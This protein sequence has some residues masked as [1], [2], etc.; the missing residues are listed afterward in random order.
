MAWRDTQTALGHFGRARVR[1]DAHPEATAFMLALVALIVVVLKSGIGVFPSWPFL[2]NLAE[3]WSDPS[4]APLLVPPADYL[5]GNFV[6]AWLAGA[7]GFV[8]PHAYIAFNLALA[9]VAIVLPFL[10][11]V[12]RRRVRTAAL[13]FIAI[14]GGP[15]A[16]VLVTW[17]GG[18]DAVSVIGI[19]IA[20]LARHSIVSGVGWLI[21][22]L[23]HPSLAL[24]GFA[25][26]IPIVALTSDRSA[27]VRR[28]VIGLVGVVL[29]AL[30]SMRVIDA[31]GG[32]TN[33]WEW[34]L[35]NE[36]MPTAT[37]ILALFLPALFGAVGVMWFVFLRPSFLH[38]WVV[39]TLVIQ[40]VVLTVLL[41]F[42]VLDVTRVIAL[43]MCAPLLTWIAVA[44]ST[45]GSR[46]VG[47]IDRQLLLPAVILPIPL[48][49]E[50]N[51]F[52][53]DPASTPS[54]FES[55]ELPEWY[56]R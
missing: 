25:A 14:V 56:P 28:V 24:L 50:G 44:E 51:V 32:A 15:I 5:K 7:L 54:V 13:L 40:I 42:F 9:A 37:E 23:N 31:W 52:F 45:H 4:L 46:S 22:G 35:T 2:L 12:V 1:V 26:W 48:V 43:V 38:T 30:V 11:P 27:T 47:A 10:M 55:L 19:V 20:A 53:G 39:R 16:L 33:R 3:N 6:A 8:S 41:P 29:G 17:V 34:F 21:V 18:Y 49:W 36:Q